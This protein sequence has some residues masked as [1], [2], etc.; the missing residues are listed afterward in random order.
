MKAFEE[1]FHKFLEER[2]PDVVHEIGQKKELPDT[3]TQRLDEAAKQC[4]TQFL[5]SDV[6]Q[7]AGAAK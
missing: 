4:K 1:A 6:A 5:A 2:Y 7:P 3:I